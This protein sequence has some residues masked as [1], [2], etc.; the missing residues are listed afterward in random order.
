MRAKSRAR[1]RQ[2]EDMALGQS[3]SSKWAGVLGIEGQVGAGCDQL[4]INKKKYTSS[5][6][7]INN[8]F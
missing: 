4:G 2:E 5:F 7:Y 8:F 3:P 1:G 6:L